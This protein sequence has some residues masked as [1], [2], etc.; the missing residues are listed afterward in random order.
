M[1]ERLDGTLREHGA[2]LEGEIRGRPQFLDGRAEHRGHT[3]PAEFGGGAQTRPATLGV[4]LIGLLEPG[5][6]DDTVW[7]PARTLPIARFVERIEHVLGELARF[8]EH[9][10]GDVE[11]IVGVAGAGLQTGFT[12]QLVQDKTQILEGR[13]IHGCLPKR[14]TPRFYP[15]SAGTMCA[16]RKSTNDFTRGSSARRAG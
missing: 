4:L 11:R 5:R 14:G 16:A 12:D 9:R 1:I 2:E 6:A 3:L 15:A 7:R 8:L 13:A 10:I